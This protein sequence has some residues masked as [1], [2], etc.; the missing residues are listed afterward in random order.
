MFCS[1]CGNKLD[2]GVN[3]C[4]KCGSKINA[5][6]ASNE[7]EF[8]KTPFWGKDFTNKKLGVNLWTNG[9]QVVGNIFFSENGLSFKSHVASNVVNNIMNLKFQNLNLEQLEFEISYSD[10]EDV[11]LVNIYAL[12]PLGLQIR[13]KDKNIYRFNFSINND[14]KKIKEFLEYKMKSC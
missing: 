2:E 13:T 11:E 10:I 1:N 5:S 7:S 12:V 4:P 6:I 14:R 8:S 3:F 9:N